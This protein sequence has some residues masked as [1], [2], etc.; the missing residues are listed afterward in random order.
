MEDLTS[1]LATVRTLKQE[2]WF[3][4]I[5]FNG[6]RKQNIIVLSLVNK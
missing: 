3:N 2:T 1:L 4:R 5:I 6:D